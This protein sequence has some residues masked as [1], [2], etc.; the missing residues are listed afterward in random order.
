[1]TAG[2]SPVLHL[3]LN[4]NLIFSPMRID[5][6]VNAVTFAGPDEL[7]ESG[8]LWEENRKQMA[9]KPAV[10]VSG[11]G[12]GWVV[13]FVTDPT[14]RGFMDGENVLFLNA[15]LRSPA[16]GRRFGQQE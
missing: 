9:Y 4:G 5:H 7:V 1:V 13:G 10:V 16:A 15:V 8:Y 11:E 2:V 6:G 12:R 14:F 3:M